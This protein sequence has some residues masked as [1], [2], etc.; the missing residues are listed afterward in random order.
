MEHKLLVHQLEFY[1]EFF[2]NALVWAIAIV[3][4]FGAGKSYTLATVAVLGI[5]RF[6]CNVA[7]YS[8]TFDLLKLVNVPQICALLE[9][10]GIKYSLNKQ[11][12]II[13]VKGYGQIILR[14]LDNPARI[15]GYEAGIS[16]ADE[17]DTLPSNK[18]M[19]AWNMIIARNRQ[20][21][22]NGMRNKV[23]VFTTPEGFN[24]VYERWEKQKTTGYKLIKAKTTDNPYLPE[25]YVQNLLD[26]YPEN[27]IDAYLKGEFV[28]LNGNSVYYS[29][30]R[31]SHHADFDDLM[32]DQ[33]SSNVVSL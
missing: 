5:L 10:F 1:K 12:M 33:A 23:G 19:Q 20:I 14:S 8:V 30:N 31:A 11:D 29:F 13:T 25:D 27:L 9:K 4:G 32:L 28:N 18:A 3:S 2:E 6:K 16:L 17:L 26:T 7:V 15:I 21:M 22:P 24:F